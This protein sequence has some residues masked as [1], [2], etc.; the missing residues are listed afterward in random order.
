MRMNRKDLERTKQL[1][2]PF[3]TKLVPN[4]RQHFGLPLESRFYAP[5]IRWPD[6]VV[7][8]VDARALEPNSWL[9]IA[10]RAVAPAQPSPSLSASSQTAKNHQSGAPDGST[11]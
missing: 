8:T 9:T 7:S 4:P 6:R 10:Q 5:E 1:Q 3:A 11:G 2:H